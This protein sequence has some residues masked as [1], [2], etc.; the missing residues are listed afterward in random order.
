MRK[1]T[2]DEL[3]AIQDLS[4]SPLIEQVSIDR[5]S[6]TLARVTVISKVNASWNEIDALL[7]AI[8]PE[9]EYRGKAGIS[10][11]DGVLSEYFSIDVNEETLINL[12]IKKEIEQKEEALLRTEAP[13]D[14]ETTHPYSTTQDEFLVQV[15]N[16]EL[17]GPCESF[18]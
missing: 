12:V 11:E 2:K 1:L 17:L 16:V 18:V 7:N 4:D 15:L 10:V 14:K 3:S 13:T 9:M 8:F 6:N 5:H